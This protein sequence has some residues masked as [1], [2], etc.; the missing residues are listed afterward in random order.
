M[1]NKLDLIDIHRP[2]MHNN[3]GAKFFLSVCTTPKKLTYTRP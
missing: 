1:V 2:L 3:C